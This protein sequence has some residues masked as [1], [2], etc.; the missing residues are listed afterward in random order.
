MSDRHHAHNHGGWPAGDGRLVSH[1]V[2]AALPLDTRAPMLARR[3]LAT[4]VGGSQLGQLTELALLVVS[5]LV[6]NAVR[7]TRVRLDLDVWVGAGFLEIGVGDD[8]PG[9]PVPKRTSP[10]S[11]GGRGL[12]LIDALVSARDVVWDPGGKVVWCRLDVAGGAA[13]PTAS[14]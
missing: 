11:E 1:P 6:T 14:C 9:E 5:E 10:W 3:L 4:S 8:A 2:H 12:A 13:T 7:L